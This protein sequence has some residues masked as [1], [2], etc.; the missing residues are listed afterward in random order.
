M[1]GH[2]ADIYHCLACGKVVYEPHG[3][4]APECCEQPMVRAVADV[5][6]GLPANS[7]P[8]P[9]SREETQPVAHAASDQ[10]AVSKI[11]ELLERCHAVEDVNR[12]CFEELRRG[13][14][15]LH[16]DLLDRF[17]VEEHSGDFARISARNGT[18]RSDVKRLCREHQQLLVELQQ[19]V[20]DL[21]KGE[22]NFRGWSDVCDRLDSFA[23]DLRGHEAKETE[24]IHSEDQA[25]ATGVN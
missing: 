22:A 2:N 5:A 16:H 23:A 9:V 25:D 3:S 8:A 10:A 24:M 21:R 19:F 1:T 15:S 11:D 17:D 12:S 7:S 20:E 6:T 18:S 13:L 4:R 14:D